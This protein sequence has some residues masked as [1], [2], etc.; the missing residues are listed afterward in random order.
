MK[1][2]GGIVAIIAGIFAIFAAGATLLIGGMASAFEAEGSGTVVGLGWGGLVFSFATV[3]LGAIVLGSKS[4]VPGIL[5]IVSSIAGVIL[6]G[7]LV[8]IFMVLA[9]LGGIL[10]IIGTKKQADVFAQASE[11]PQ[12]TSESSIS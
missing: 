5:L 6:G 4:K 9:L 3:V 10:A 1:K 12:V 11:S 8:A 2:A 7:T